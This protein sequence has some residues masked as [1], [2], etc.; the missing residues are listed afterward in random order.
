MAV[1]RAKRK[2]SLEESSYEFRR[3]SKAGSSLN[4]HIYA[5]RENLG[6]VDIGR[7]SLY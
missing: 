2:H 3:W 5:K 7:G 1:R 4:L 6:E